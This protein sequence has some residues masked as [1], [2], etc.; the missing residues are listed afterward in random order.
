MTASDTGSESMRRLSIAL[1]SLGLFATSCAGAGPEIPGDGAARPSPRLTTQELPPSSSSVGPEASPAD[2]TISH[3]ASELSRELAGDDRLA[4]V[5][6]LE[7]KR[8]VVHWHGPVDSRL[9]DLLDRFSKIQISVQT[10]SCSPGQLREYGS[11]LLTTDPAVNIV[12][13]APDGSHLRVTLD[14]SLKA[15]SDVTSLE[16]KYSDAVGCPVKVEFG[17]VMPIGG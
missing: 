17:G 5:E 13:V 15:I 2:I 7:G 9:R 14:E 10:S 6:V 11:E 1:M 4:S 3:A 8:I 12:A 16:R